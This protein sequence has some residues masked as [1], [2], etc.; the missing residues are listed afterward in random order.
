MCPDRQLISLYKDGE[1]P[2]PWKEKLEAHIQ[3]CPECTHTL[4]AYVHLSGF[5]Q[6]EQL[7]SEQIEV[8]Q[9][10][11]WKHLSHRLPQTNQV[12][13]KRIWKHP[14]IIPLPAA[15]AA[16]VAVALLASFITPFILHQGTKGTQNI[17]KI[18]T[19]VPGIVPVSDMHGLLQYLEN[20]A[21]AADIVIIKLPDTSSFIPSGQPEIIRAVDYQGRR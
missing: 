18:N 6:T 12:K 7:T 14:L 15:I 5:L 8:V 1:L 9:K 13:T 17:A 10:N 3:T 2:S 4:R 16:L 19:E 11:I 21:S 20:Q